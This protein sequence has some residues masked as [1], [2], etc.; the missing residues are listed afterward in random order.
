MTTNTPAQPSSDPRYPMGRFH[1]PPTIDAAAIEDA[2]KTLQELPQQLRNAVK[3][4]NDAQLATPYREGGWTVRQTVHHVADSHMNAYIRMKLALTENAPVIKT[5]EEALWAEL[6]DGKNAPVEWS[7]QLLEA[8]HARWVTM[9][10]SLKDEQWQRTFAH[11]EHGPLNLQ[12]AVL[13]YDWHSRHHLA[14]ITS[15]R[16]AKGW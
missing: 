9:L 12:T 3:D 5:Y 14:H 10:R 8:L 2:L 16:E 4:L 1:N 7:L 6:S 15:L 13:M 11:P